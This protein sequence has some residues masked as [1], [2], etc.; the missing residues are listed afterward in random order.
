MLNPRWYK[1]INDLSGNKTR[2]LLIVLSIA[3]GLFAVG[4]ILSA[5][6]ILSEGLAFSFAAIHPS[7]G[8]VRTIEQQADLVSSRHVVSFLAWCM[9]AWLSACVKVAPESSSSISPADIK[10]DVFVKILAINDFHGHL[11]TDRQPGQPPM[12]GAAVLASYLRAAQQ[13]DWPERTFIVHAGD[14]VGASPPASALLQDEPAIM[15]LNVLANE[16]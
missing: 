3:V 8:T 13:G 10:Q 11:S 16:R 1:V 2:T 14:H 12:G 9:I 5:R 15:F 6:S 7:S 4:I